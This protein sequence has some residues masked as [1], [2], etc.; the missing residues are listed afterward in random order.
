MLVGNLLSFLLIFPATLFYAVF[1]ILFSMSLFFT[2]SFFTRND[3][4]I[5]WTR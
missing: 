5:S 4:K 1:N 3:Q 2:K